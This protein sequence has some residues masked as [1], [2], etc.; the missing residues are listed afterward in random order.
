MSSFDQLR[1]E[2]PTPPSPRPVTLNRLAAAIAKR[3][4]AIGAI[5]VEGDVHRPS[6]PASGRLY[7]TLRDRTAQISVQMSAARA[8]HVALADGERVAVTGSISWVP[9]RGQLVLDATDVSPVGEAA[10]AAAIARTRSRLESEGLLDRARKPIPLLPMAIGVVCGSEAAVRRDIESVVAVR[11]PG[12]PMHFLE[13]TVAGSGAAESIAT[14]IELLDRRGIVEVIVLA[15]GGGD[16]AQLLP[17]SDERVCRAVCASRIPVVSAIGHENDRPLC[18]EVADLRAGTPSIAAAQ[19]VPHR[20]ELQ[21]RVDSVIERAAATMERSVDRAAGRVHSKAWLTALDRRLDRAQ[22]ALD[23]VDWRHALDRRWDRAAARLAAVAWRDPLPRRTVE[24]RRR[25]DALRRE[26]DALSP[27]RVLDRGYAIV[28]TSD[29]SVV[30][31]AERV[32][33]GTVISVTVAEGSFEA[34]VRSAAGADT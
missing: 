7:F 6:R 11:F 25:L 30:R 1:F 26:L 19:V 5:V 9:D 21:A 18:D 32:D 33:A 22:S 10:V 28:R 2:P 16:A 17:F 24:A 12:Y 20:A 3:V 14:A 8:R 34:E 4:S 15:R 13:T 23:R 29:G 31:Q 27:A